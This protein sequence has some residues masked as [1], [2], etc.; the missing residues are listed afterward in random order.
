MKTKA[1]TVAVGPK[2]AKSRQ[3]GT[4]MTG[5][6]TSSRTLTAPLPVSDGKRQRSA[7]VVRRRSTVEV[8]TA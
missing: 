2:E 5:V 7:S 3:L 6:T 4:M 8:G 1:R